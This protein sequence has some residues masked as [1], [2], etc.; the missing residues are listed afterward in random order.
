MILKQKLSKKILRTTRQMVGLIVV[1]WG[2]IPFT[3]SAA[4]VREFFHKEIQTG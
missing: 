4:T 2:I 1:I 3:A